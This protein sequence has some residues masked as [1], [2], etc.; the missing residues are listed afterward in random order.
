M[1]ICSYADACGFFFKFRTRE[2]LVWKG[3]VKNYCMEGNICAR[4]LIF[5]AGRVPESDDLMPVGVHASK[6]FLSLP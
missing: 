3:M 5:D 1:M 2:S 4:R 6:A